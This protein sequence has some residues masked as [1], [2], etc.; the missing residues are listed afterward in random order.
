VRRGMPSDVGGRADAVR[1]PIHS[2]A[3]G[4]ALYGWRHVPRVTNATTTETSVK[5][6]LKRAAAWL[7][8]MF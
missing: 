3:V 5:H 1:S 4:L 7:G 8:G 6:A 2:T